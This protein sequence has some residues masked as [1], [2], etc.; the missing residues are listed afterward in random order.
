MRTTILAALVLSPTL[1]LA[2]P[3][4]TNIGDGAV[5]LPPPPHTMQMFPLDQS[6]NSGGAGI[7]DVKSGGHPTGPG[8]TQGDTASTGPINDIDPGRGNSDPPQAANPQP[9]P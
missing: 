4:L 7:S 3:M 6:G 2:K 5:P 8:V 9:V 1:A